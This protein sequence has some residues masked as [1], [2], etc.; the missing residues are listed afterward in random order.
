MRNKS[1]YQE[2]DHKKILT[3]NKKSHRINQLYILYLYIV[4]I[5]VFPW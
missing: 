1:L 3:I 2:E 4:Y 5:Y